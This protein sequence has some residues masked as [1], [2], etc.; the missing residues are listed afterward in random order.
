MGPAETILD[1]ALV[2]MHAVDVLEGQFQQAYLIGDC[3]KKLDH[4]T[5]AYFSRKRASFSVTDAIKIEV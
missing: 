2:D 3:S 5:K 1:A 4:F